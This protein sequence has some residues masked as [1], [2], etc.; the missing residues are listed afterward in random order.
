MN[1]CR[2]YTNY[3]RVQT[4][5][6]LN[7]CLLTTVE[8]LQIIY[9]LC[10]YKN[11]HYFKKMNNCRKYT[12]YLRVQTCIPLNFCS[13][14]TVEQLQII[15]KLCAYKNFHYFKKMNNC[16]KYTNYLR[17]QTC[18]PLT[19]CLLTTV[20]QWQKIHKLCACTNVHG[21]NFCFVYLP[22][23]NNCKKY[24][25]YVPLQS[26]I[27]FKKSYP[28]VEQLQKIHKLCACTY[29]HSLNFCS[30]ATVKQPQK[31]RGLFKYECK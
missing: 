13:L 5:I 19:F 16:R 17:V 20:K 27:N 8:Q 9:K 15:Y 30:L 2:K 10:A 11:F 6:P 7:F 12:N 28:A 21:L 4:C 14:T 29:L 24:T 1:N 3:L 26:C 18:I 31:I 23:L 22:Q 25:N